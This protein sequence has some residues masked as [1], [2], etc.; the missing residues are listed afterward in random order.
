MVEKIHLPWV[1]KATTEKE[2][3][4]HGTAGEKT[5]DGRFPQQKEYSVNPEV[6]PSP[7]APAYPE[8]LEVGVSELASELVSEAAP[9]PPSCLASQTQTPEALT[10]QVGEAEEKQ[11][12]KRRSRYSDLNPAAQTVVVNLYPGWIPGDLGVDAAQLNSVAAQQSDSGLDWNE[13]FAWHRAHKPPKLIFRDAARFLAGWEYAVNDYATHDPKTCAVC[14][15]LGK[16]EQ[17]PHDTFVRCE[18]CGGCASP[19]YKDE[20]FCEK[21]YPKY[22]RAA[23]GLPLIAEKPC[24]CGDKR[25]EGHG[26]FCTAEA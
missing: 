22:S 21:C 2:R 10:R 23:A 19:K 14:L 18:G 9:P 3:Y 5:D 4:P 8:P 26:G 6:P 1:K 20:D 17:H 13:F 15:K 7:S 16:Q 25:G 12:T 24:A 11:K